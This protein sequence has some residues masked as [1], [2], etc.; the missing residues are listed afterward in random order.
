[1]ISLQGLAFAAAYT[2]ELA[3]EKFA[4]A[5]ASNPAVALLYGEI[6]NIET[7]SGYMVYRSVPFLA[8][9]GALWG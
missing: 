8:L 5:I 9:I 3:R 7:P 2:S 4:T 1:M 6:R